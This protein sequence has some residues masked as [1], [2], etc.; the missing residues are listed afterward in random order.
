MAKHTH[1]NDDHRESETEYSVG[2]KKPPRPSRFN[3]GKS[4]NPGG[5]P[6]GSRNLRTLFEDALDETVIVSENGRRR[7]I[8]KREAISKQ[9]VNKAASGDARSIKLLVDLLQRANTNGEAYSDE[10]TLDDDDQKVLEDLIRRW[11]PKG[12]KDGNDQS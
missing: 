6:V 2:Y 7:V 10:I 1:D 12:E 11:A 8:S 3:K 4:G 5:R 9:L